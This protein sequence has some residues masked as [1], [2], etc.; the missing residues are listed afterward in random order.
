[1]FDIEKN[2]THTH[3]WYGGGDFL[4]VVTDARVAVYTDFLPVLGE[5]TSLIALD[6][7][8]RQWCN[9]WR[10]CLSGI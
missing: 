4:Q 5:R 2:Q 1:M 10:G 8:T 3:L 6:G 9:H 7:T